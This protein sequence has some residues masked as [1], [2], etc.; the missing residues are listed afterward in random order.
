MRDKEEKLIDMFLAIAPW[1]LIIMAFF[2]GY[3]YGQDHPLPK[4]PPTIWSS[5][6]KF[7]EK[8]FHERNKYDPH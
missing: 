1:V 5:D 6:S 4:R 8:E 2:V 3:I 7:F